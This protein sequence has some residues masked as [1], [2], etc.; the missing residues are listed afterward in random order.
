MGN[1]LPLHERA[2]GLLAVRP[3]TRRELHTRL[4][5][6]GFDADEVGAELDRLQ[7]VGLVDDV[8]FAA[9]FVEHA[10]DRRLE[11]RRS[12][13]SRLAA[14]G[15]DR[16]L[17]RDALEAA[18]G[19][20]EER[21]ERLARARAGRLGGLAPDAAYRR[22]VSFLVRRGHEPSAARAVAARVLRSDADASEMV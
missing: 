9:D 5:R 2:L 8:R 20:D 16:S 12:I 6:A 10:L 17:I 1:K 13:A 22:L 21:L 7:Q 11:G 3:R 19:D 18:G 15:L 4:L 14:K